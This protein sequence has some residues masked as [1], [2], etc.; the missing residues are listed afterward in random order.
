MTGKIVVFSTCG[1]QEEAERIASALVDSRVAA[2]V[3]ILP[4]LT[5]I[6]RWQGV[7]EKASEW[8]LLI[9]TRRELFDDLSRE[10]KRVHSYETPEMLAVDVA[11]GFAPYLKWIDD[12][13]SAG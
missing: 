11:A 1:S 4:G 7:V 12:E 10:L 6:Y 3:S 2:C 9:K 13:T 8:L 5:S